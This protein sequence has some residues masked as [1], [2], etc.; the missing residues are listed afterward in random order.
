MEDPTVSTSVRRATVVDTALAAL[1]NRRGEARTALAAGLES[2]HARLHERSVPTGRRTR[3]WPTTN[4]EAET[5][6]RAR[7]AA[8]EVKAWE[9]ESVRGL[10]AR[11]DAL[12]IETASLSEQIRPFVDEYGAT[13]W[14]RFFLVTSSAGGHIHASMDC[15]TC[16]L[17]TAYG[18]LPEVSGLTEADAVAAYGPRLCTVC[19]PTAPVEWTIGEAKAVDPRVCPGSG[20]PARSDSHRRRTSFCVACGS[21]VRASATGLAP[22]HHT[23]VRG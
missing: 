4:P 2:I 19:F 11:I 15:S 18:W 6:L 23:P 7:L 17:T 14:N 5:L 13:R 20:K 22:R 9:V 8:G 16:H 1:W 3:T 12:R 10:L 21:A